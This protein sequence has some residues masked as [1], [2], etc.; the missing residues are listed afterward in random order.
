MIMQKFWRSGFSPSPS[1][2]APATLV[3]N[4]FAANAISTQKKRTIAISVAMTY[5]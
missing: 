5:G 4:G 1:A 3:E 2:R